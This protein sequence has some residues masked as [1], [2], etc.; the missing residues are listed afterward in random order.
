MPV[1]PGRAGRSRRFQH[2]PLTRAACET[3]ERRAVKGGWQAQGG[4]VGV[5]L[6]TPTVEE[7][8]KILDEAEGDGHDAGKGKKPKT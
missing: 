5:I 8:R 3:V 4:D 7:T 1:Q 6:P 2:E